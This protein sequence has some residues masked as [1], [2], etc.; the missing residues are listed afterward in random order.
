M[1]QVFVVSKSVHDYSAAKDF[2]ELVYLSEGPFDRFATSAI[3]RIFNE[4]LA[5]SM[6]EDYLLISGYTVM[7]C[8]ASAIFAAMHKRVNLLLYRGKRYAERVILLG[9]TGSNS[10]SV[11]IS[12]SCNEEVSL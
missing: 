7:N 3:A 6:P 5:R 2:G 9:N 1:P 4:K 8:I 11:G 10:S 12:G